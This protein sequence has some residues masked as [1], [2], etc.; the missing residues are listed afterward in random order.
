[1]NRNAVKESSNYLRKRFNRRPDLV[2]VLGSGLG[3][4]ADTLEERVVVRQ[5][6]IPD[7]PVSS[8][9]GHKGQLV[10]GTLGEATVLALQGRVHFYE[11]RD[12]DSLLHP[13]HVA[14]ELG[15][16]TLVATNAA[17]GINRQ[18]TPGDLMLITDQINLTQLSLSKSTNNHVLY[19]ARLVNIIADTAREH[20]IPMR[21]GVYVGLKGPS[22]ESKAEI[23]MLSTIGADAVGMSTVMEVSLAAALGMEVVGI[24]CITNLGTGIA[25]GK[26]SH[27]EVG[28]VAAKV[29][30]RFGT[31][32]SASI[33]RLVGNA[34]QP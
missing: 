13:I 4:F 6:E 30:E 25:S 34:S 29:K 27:E 20:G 12:L 33:R 24:S 26:L 15:A 7:Y 11:S 5:A 9:E 23:A 32:L 14:A 16:R 1:M 28:E 3:S 19:S 8:V 18:F 17:G 10:L 22:Y 2:V 31:L 21:K